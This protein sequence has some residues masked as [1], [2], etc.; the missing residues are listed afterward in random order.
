MTLADGVLKQKDFSLIE[1]EL[2]V[3]AVTAVHDIPYI[4]YAHTRIALRAGMSEEQVVSASK[5]VEPVGLQDAEKVIYATALELAETKVPLK[6]ETWRKAE[7]T[8]GKA[9]CARLAHVV[10]WYLYAASLVR[11]GAVDVPPEQ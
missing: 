11:L 4:L 8:L 5:G 6:E 7:A 10:G 9:R 2:V 3:L 1:R